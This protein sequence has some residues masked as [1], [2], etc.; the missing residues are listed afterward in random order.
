[1]NKPKLPR[2]F[3]GVDVPSAE[4]VWR[5]LELISNVEGEYGIKLNLDVVVKDWSMIRKVGDQTGCPVFVDMKMLNGGR[6]MAEIVDA[7]AD[8]GGSMVNAYAMADHLLEK[9][10]RVADDQGVV[11]LGVTW[12][13][14]FTDEYCWE[15]FNRPFRKVVSMFAFMAMNRGCDGYILPGLPLPFQLVF[16]SI[17]FKKFYRQNTQLCKRIRPRSLFFNTQGKR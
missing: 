6:T 8:Q 11:L 12:P 14:H 1:M 13:T 7:V 15:V 5:H 10:V 4:D 17:F 16:P 9:A 3:L 2:F